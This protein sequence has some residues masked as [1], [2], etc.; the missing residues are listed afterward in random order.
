[1]DTEARLR[2]LEGKLRT[3]RRITLALGAMLGAACM[4]ALAD[5]DKGPVVG[6]AVDNGNF[7]RLVNRGRVEMLDKDGKDWKWRNYK[8]VAD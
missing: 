4:M 8:N 1:M 6:F 3:Q 2:S 5:D 7:Y